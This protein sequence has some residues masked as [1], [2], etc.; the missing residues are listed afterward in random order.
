VSSSPPPSAFPCRQWI[1]CAELHLEAGSPQQA[2]FCYEEALLLR[3]TAPEY[4][5]RLAEVRL[6]SHLRAAVF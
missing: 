4:H 3:P 6:H 5:V 2:A 1:E